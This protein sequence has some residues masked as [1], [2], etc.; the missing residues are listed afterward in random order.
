MNFM[1]VDELARM[2]QGLAAFV[3]VAEA[4]EAE[5]HDEDALKGKGRG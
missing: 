2:A 4:Q 5:M 3:K 1:H